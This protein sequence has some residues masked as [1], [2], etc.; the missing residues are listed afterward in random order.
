MIYPF[1]H[2]KNYVGTAL[3]SRCNL[4][5]NPYIFAHLNI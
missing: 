4:C 2:Y 3:A 5:A 1:K